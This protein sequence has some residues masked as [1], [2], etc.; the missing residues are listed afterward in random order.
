MSVATDRLRAGMTEPQPRTPKASNNSRPKWP[1]AYR[2]IYKICM[3]QNDAAGLR[4][5]QT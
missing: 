3:Y 1:F 4:R 5:S 2:Q